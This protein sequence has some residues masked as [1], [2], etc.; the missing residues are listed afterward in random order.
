MLEETQKRLSIINLLKKRKKSFYYIALI[1]IILL[2]FYIRTRN[3]PLLNDNPLAL[4][5]YYFLRIARHITEHGSVMAWDNLRYSPVGQDPSY[6]VMILPYVISYTYKILRVFMPGITIERADILY[7]A[8]FFALS[9]PF[10]YLLA[11]L[12]FNRNIAFPLQ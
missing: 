7:P 9:L 8:I 2:G 11:K 5:P 6:E 4:D 10:F 1:L 3:I 12:F